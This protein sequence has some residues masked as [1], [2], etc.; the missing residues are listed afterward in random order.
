MWAQSLCANT[1]NT[2]LYN[3]IQVLKNEVIF[4]EFEF[5]AYIGTVE[6]EFAK[7][8]NGAAFSMNSRSID[9]V[10][11]KNVLYKKLLY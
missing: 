1:L 10:Q 6:F 2:G 7:S 4:C 9:F 11:T 5:V 3:E 8:K